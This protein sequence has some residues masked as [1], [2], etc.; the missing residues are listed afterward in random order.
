[1][2]DSGFITN[3]SENKILKRFSN[4]QTAHVVDIMHETIWTEKPKEK[5]EEW[6]WHNGQIT[7]TDKQIQI[8]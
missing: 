8:F 4:I 3:L 5:E 1:M 7:V 6:I 2:R